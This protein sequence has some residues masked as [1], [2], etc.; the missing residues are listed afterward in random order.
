MPD[1]PSDSRPGKVTHF[2][3]D[4]FV[5]RMHAKYCADVQLTD[6]ILRQSLA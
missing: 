2:V 1:I 3:H 6:V 4:L 5:I